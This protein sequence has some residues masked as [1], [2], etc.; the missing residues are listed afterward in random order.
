[1]TP[2]GLAW[3]WK[4]KEI[5]KQE[6]VL[7]SKAKNLGA[8]PNV[9]STVRTCVEIDTREKERS[10]EERDRERWRRDEERGHVAHGHKP[11][12][13]EANEEQDLLS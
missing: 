13:C 6:E 5:L 11:T 12:D 4:A 7:V 3:I 10:M 1:M 8:V 9:Q 2:G